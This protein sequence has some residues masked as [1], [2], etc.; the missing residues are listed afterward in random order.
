L[1]INARD[2][3]PAG[4]VLRIVARND[5]VAEQAARQHSGA[6]AGRFVTIEVAD[7]GTGMPA[8]TLAQIWQPFFTTKPEGQ[9]TGLGLSTVRGIVANHG[10]FLTVESQVGQGT[11]F[12]VFLPVAD[13]PDLGRVVVDSE[14]RSVPRG[15]G[16]VVFVVDDQPSV[17]ESIAVVLAQHGYRP[18]TM[19]DGIEALSKH[20]DR[21]SDAALVVTDLDMPGLSGTSFAHAMLQLNPT[22]K[23]LFI[24]GTG[25]NS[26]VA[27]APAIP[28]TAFLGKPFAP[29]TLLTRIDELLHATKS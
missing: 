28:G 17:R 12:Q 13:E 16:E 15:R 25:D 10:G 20:A 9:G 22:A 23:V 24:S 1:C 27:Q 3:M 26:N 6:T 5:V 14:R 2:A 11:K 19:S 21:I 29:E 18:L 4:G 8:E 7:T